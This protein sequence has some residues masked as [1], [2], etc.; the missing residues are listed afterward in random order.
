MTVF[1]DIPLIIDDTKSYTVFAKELTLLEFA[2]M[3]T[4][5]PT[6][7]FNAAIV[8]ASPFFRFF[9]TTVP[10]S[11]IL[12][13]SLFTVACTVWISYSTPLYFIGLKYVDHFVFPFSGTETYG[14]I[15][16][17]SP[18]RSKTSCV[19]RNSTPYCVSWVST[20]SSSLSILDVSCPK[21]RIFSK[22]I[23]KSELRLKS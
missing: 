18:N 13:D 9:R 14:I 20:S 22:E 3:V 16:S 21:S 8:P 5:T 2:T 4:P 1:V 10:V 7:A 12:D 15:P 17:S 11:Y 6:P 23:D 19:V